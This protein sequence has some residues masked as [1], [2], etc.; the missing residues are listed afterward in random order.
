ME[1]FMNIANMAYL[2]VCTTLNVYGG[3]K[4][5][6]TKDLN[7]AEDNPPIER[8]GRVTMQQYVSQYVQVTLGPQ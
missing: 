3:R 6:A 5:W 2:W 8:E 4:Y 7:F 1:L